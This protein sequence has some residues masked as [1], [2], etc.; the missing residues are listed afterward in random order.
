MA[1]EVTLDFA[2]PSE[3]QANPRL[4]ARVVKPGR[5]GWVKTGV[6][7]GL[8][9]SWQVEHGRFVPAHVG[10]LRRMYALYSAT[11]SS[12]ALRHYYYSS[13]RADVTIDLTSFDR[14]IWRPLPLP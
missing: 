11:T 14:S 1:I 13:A 3:A 6:S 7:W 12:G 4:V 10:I 5:S 8:L 2:G 9:D